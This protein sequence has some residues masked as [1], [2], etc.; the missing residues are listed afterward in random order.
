MAKLTQDEILRYQKGRRSQGTILRYYLE[1]RSQ[2][3]P[4]LPVRC[5]IESCMFYTSALL[6]NGNTLSPI[7]DHKNGVNG[8]NRPENLRLLCPNCNSQQ[9]TQGGRNKGKVEQSEGGFATIRP[10]G[11][12]DYVL[13]AEPGRYKIVD[14][15][16]VLINSKP[17]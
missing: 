10:D 14:E 17:A 12:K 11:K 6:W 7:L 16:A 4:L 8:D 1:W 2:Q 3:I 15:Q 13:P 5:D 9:P